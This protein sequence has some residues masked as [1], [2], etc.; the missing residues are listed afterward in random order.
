MPSSTTTTPPSPYSRKVGERL[1]SIRRQKRLSLQDVEALE[2]EFKARC[3]A[4]TS[5]VS[6]RSRCPASSGWPASTRCRSTS[7]CPRRATPATTVAEPGDAADKVAV[8]LV[9]LGPAVRPAVRDAGPLPADDPGPAPGLQ[10]QG[11]HDPRRRHPGDRGDARRARRPGR[12]RSSTRSICCFGPTEPPRAGRRS[13]VSAPF[14]VYVHIPFCAR[15]L[16]LLRVRDLD[17][18]APP[19]RRRTSTRCAPTSTAP[20][21]TACRAADE[22]VRRRR[23]AVAGAGRRLA[24]VLAVDPGGAPAPRSRSSATR[25]TSPPSSLP[26]YRDGGVNRVSLGVQSMVPHVLASPRPHARSR[27]TSPR[28]RGRPRGGHSTFNLDLIYGAAG[29]SLADWERTVR[30]ALALEPPHVVAYGLTVEAGTPLADAAERH[31]D[32]DDQ[33]DKYE[34]ADDAADRRRPR[35]LRGLQLGPARP[36]VP[37]QPAVLAPGRLPGFGCAAHSHRAGRRWWN[38]RTPER[39]IELV[40]RGEPDRGGRRG[41]STPTTRRVEGLQLALRTREG[42]P[43]DAL[44]G[45]E[46]PDGLVE[47]R[48]RR[49]RAH[50]PR[51]AAGQRGVAA[52]CS[53][54][55]RAGEQIGEHLGDLGGEVVAV[56]AVPGVHARRRPSGRGVV[57]RR[58][59]RATPAAA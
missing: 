6:G 54:A 44:D 14:G 27:P 23:H 9:K 47:P 20:S 16:R 42:V 41:R 26:R 3:S 13:A 7:C 46:L 58:L 2:H 40:G 28:G 19:R 8:D 55:D 34:L 36:R 4:P 15:A 45:D 12:D 29:E 31:P 17:R 32:D 51:P 50:P 10:R 43:A 52:A 38:V 25:T 56:G 18:P 48:R 21:P 59:R 11:A 39:Y 24:A 53:S 35:Q 30:G 22:R 33:A 49:C 37:A 5:A 1:R 57:G